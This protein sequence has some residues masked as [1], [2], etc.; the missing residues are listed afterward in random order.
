VTGR[1]L[2]AARAAEG[3]F[4]CL[5]RTRHSAQRAAMMPVTATK[6]PACQA[7]D[8]EKWCAAENA[9]DVGRPGSA[10]HVHCTQPPAAAPARPA[11]VTHLRSP[12][13]GAHPLAISCKASS[14]A[15]SRTRSPKVPD[16]KAGKPFTSAGQGRETHISSSTPGPQTTTATGSNAAMR[17]EREVSPYD[18]ESDRAGLDCM[19]FSM[20]HARE[21]DPCKDSRWFK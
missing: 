9:Q 10:H 8:R 5:T 6:N 15:G 13:A 12:G 14:A 17:I 4:S 2:I 11:T 16:L 19:P 20:N 3:L 7:P 1:P 21:E 18:R